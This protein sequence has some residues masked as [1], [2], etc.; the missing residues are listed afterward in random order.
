VIQ[1]CQHCIVPLPAIHLLGAED[2][3]LVLVL[4]D[5]YSCLECHLDLAVVDLLLVL[6]TGADVVYVEG[7]VIFHLVGLVLLLAA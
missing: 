6:L 5:A 3:S 4:I 2:H 1:W 7:D